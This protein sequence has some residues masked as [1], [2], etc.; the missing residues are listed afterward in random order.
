M[1]VGLDR[2]SGIPL[3]E[4][5][6]HQIRTGIRSGRLAAGTRLPSTRSLASELAVS[7]TVVVDAYTQLVAEGYLASRRGAPTR[8]TA[9]ARAALPTTPAR[10]LA[11]TFAYHFHPGLP[12][13]AAFPRDRWLSS[14]RR[15]LRENALAALGYPDP[16][17]VPQLRDALAAYLGRVRGAAADPERILVCSGFVHAF[18]VLCRVLRRRGARRV[19]M[20]E[21][22]WLFH[23]L[24]IERAGLEPVP[25]PVDALGLRFDALAHT[26]ADAVVV[27]PAHQFPTGAVLGSERRG[28]LLDW[29]ER[30]ETLIV[31]DDYDAEYRYDIN[32]VGA[33]QG[34]APEWVVYAGSASKRLAPGL[35]LG[36]LLMPAWLAEDLTVE[37]AL[38]DAGSDVVGQLALADF[39]TR[40]DLDR[41]VRR[42][43]QRYRARRDTLLEALARWIPEAG[44]E[45]IAAGLYA[46]VLLPPG[47]S[48]SALLASAAERDVGMEGLSWHRAD[49][50]DGPPGLLLGYANLPEAAIGN[51]IQRIAEA[52]AAPVAARL[53]NTKASSTNPANT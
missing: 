51:G 14:V 9:A 38:D 27:T 52:A 31:E 17:G 40:G 45:G 41:H 44:V 11:P 47:V 16:R 49:S 43:R 39:I 48:E 12:D 36:W 53:P 6:E 1:L 37:K 28:A 13:L 32:A 10:S 26:E 3:H 29:A 25:I 18:A 8:V 4:Q 34:L 33:L 35:R 5:L 20:E 7:R 46:L 42:M 15:A 30:S 50:S 22:G 2:H 19:A 23:R 21:P 24:I